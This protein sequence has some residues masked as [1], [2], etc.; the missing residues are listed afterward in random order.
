MKLFV[1]RRLEGFEKTA[2]KE[3]RNPDNWANEIL[4]HLL[5]K[6]SYIGTYPT[7]V[8]WS[9]KDPENGHA[10]GY[11]EISSGQKQVKVPFFVKSNDLLDMDT[12]IADKKI[13]PLTEPRL[14]TALFS[15]EAFSGA[16]KKENVVPPFMA[17]TGQSAL[18]DIYPPSTRY[19]FGQSVKLSMLK[20]LRP[21]MR[22]GDLKKIASALEDKVL[23]KLAV[24]NQGVLDALKVMAESEKL[25]KRASLSAEPGM[26][27]PEVVQV[28]ALPDNQYSVKTA[29]S[30][31]YRVNREIL[32]RASAIVKYGSTSVRVADNNGSI[33]AAVYPKDTNGDDESK[34]VSVRRS[35]IY[36]VLATDGGLLTGLI[37][38]DVCD[39]EGNNMGA[40]LFVCGD[41]YSM[42]QD[43]RGE[44]IGDINFHEWQP[45]ATKGIGAFV[46]DEDDEGFNRNITWHKWKATVPLRIEKTEVNTEVLSEKYSALKSM[47]NEG[48]FDTAI[49]AYKALEQRFKETFNW[50][51]LDRTKTALEKISKKMSE[52]NRYDPNETDVDL[53]EVTSLKDQADTY[54]K[55]RDYESAYECAMRAAALPV[56][57]PG[58]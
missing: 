16:E 36:K 48:D 58:K 43:I 31:A 28:I 11:V 32:D 57:L 33:T 46:W 51:Y 17:V 53:T 52:F 20:E 8:V 29:S 39:L 37:V 55:Q 44:R 1:D 41:K 7:K 49:T 45:K 54:F 56:G 15:S 27:D 25:E 2:Q 12:M 4:T 35:G 47:I 5:D 26:P 9:S 13:L 14:T 34:L 19:G 23:H 10:F 50:F 3:L 6:H 40:K 30:K 21:T 42:Q 24:N 22:E 18:G 38:S